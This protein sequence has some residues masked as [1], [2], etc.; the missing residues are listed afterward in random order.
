MYPLWKSDFGGK[1]SD[2]FYNRFPHIV[3]DEQVSTRNGGHRVVNISSLPVGLSQG[4]VRWNLFMSVESDLM[5]TYL[6]D[7]LRYS[8]HTNE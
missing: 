1:H 4:R 2:Y 5:D 3:N 8:L 6:N 7:G